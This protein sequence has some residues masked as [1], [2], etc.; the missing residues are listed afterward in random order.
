[1]AAGQEQQIMTTT[2]TPT[3]YYLGG[4]DENGIQILAEDNNGP[5]GAATAFVARVFS[6]KDAAFVL[7]ACNAH[8]AL[9]V[10]LEEAHAALVS[11][12]TLENDEEL[13]TELNKAD[14]IVL[15]ALKLAK[16]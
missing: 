1:V 16:G 13:N 7:T 5:S 11:V 10:A 8:D 14:D 12:P 2:H 9:V 6:K 15:A 4:S 3:P